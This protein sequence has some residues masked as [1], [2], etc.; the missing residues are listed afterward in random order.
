VVDPGPASTIPSLLD[1]LSRVTDGV[2]LVLLTHIHLDHSGGVGQFCER[3]RDAAVAAHPRA[4]R[5]LVDP[6]K[7]WRSSLEI[8]MDVAEMYGAP[9]PLDERLLV[10]LDRISGIEAI[11]TPGHSS[12]HISFIAPFGSRRLFFVGEAGGTYLGPMSLGGA[13]YLRPAT[14]PKFDGDAAKAS[15]RRIGQAIRRDDT[16]CYAHWGISGQPGNTISLAA[17]QLDEWFS[18]IFKMRDQST[19]AIIDHLLSNDQLLSRYSMLTPDVRERERIFI[20]NSV[21]G[22]LGYF[23]DQA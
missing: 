19:T 5:H 10:D 2:D 18:V 7:L 13:P 3:Y 20:E 22:F 8:L 17:S 1:K 23:E 11:E 12:H 4:W 15:L 6:G 9:A 16:L 21:N 14:P